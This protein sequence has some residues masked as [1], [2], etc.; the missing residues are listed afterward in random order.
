MHSRLGAG[1]GSEGW[2]LDVVL[3]RVVVGTVAALTQAGRDRREEAFGI[4]DACCRVEEL[5]LRHEEALGQAVNLLN[6]EDGIGLEEGD[7]GFQCL[8][9][10]GFGVGLAAVVG[11]GV[12]DETALLAFPNLPAKLLRRMAFVTRS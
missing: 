10:F 11:V 5:L 3:Q 9:G 4:G 8:A 6:I 1:E 12:D 7:I 2:H